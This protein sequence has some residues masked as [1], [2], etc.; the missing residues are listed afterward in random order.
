MVAEFFYKKIGWIARGVCVT[1]TF[2]CMGYAFMLS[3]VKSVSF[4]KSMYFLV[5]EDTKV[6][7]F[8]DLENTFKSIGICGTPI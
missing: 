1:V 3:Q 6:K 4:H 8:R 7:T 5:T 2:L